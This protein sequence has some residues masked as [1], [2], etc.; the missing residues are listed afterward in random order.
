[1]L[2]ARAAGSSPVGTANGLL[3]ESFPPESTLYWRTLPTLPPWNMDTLA[4]YARSLPAY[5]VGRTVHWAV[6]QLGLTPKS[7]GG[8]SLW[9]GLVTEAAKLAS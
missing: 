3:G 1:M 4:V 7:Y 6:Q 8:H 2:T 9:A 5:E